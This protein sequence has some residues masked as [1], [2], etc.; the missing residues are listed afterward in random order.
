MAKNRLFTAIVVFAPAVLFLSQAVAVE[1]PGGESIL[2]VGASAISISPTQFPVRSAGGG[3]VD[4]STTALAD[5]L[6]SRCIVVDDGH[7]RIAI[8]VL[9]VTEFSREFADQ[10]KDATSARLGLRTDRILI[11]ATHTHSAPNTYGINVDADKKYMRLLVERIPLGIEQAVHNLRPAR[12]GWTVIQDWEHTHTR[13]W[14]RRPDKVD[15]DPL[16]ARTVRANMHPGFQNPDVIGPAGPSDP[17][18]SIVAFQGLDGHPIALLAH[19]SQHYYGV[20][21]LANGTPVLSADYFGAFASKIAGL[22]APDPASVWSHGFESSVYGI[23]LIKAYTSTDDTARAMAKDAPPLF[24]AIMAQGTSGDQQW[25]DYS[26]PAY[27]PGLDAYAHTI[28][29]EVFNAYRGIAYRNWAPVRM[30]ET[31]LT[32]GTRQPDAQEVQHAREVMASLHGRAPR[33]VT[34]SYAAAVMRAD[35]LPRTEELKLQAIAIGDLGFTAIPNEVYAITG[36]KIKAQSPF[37]TTINME[38]A[39]G[40][41]GYIPP[42]EQHVLG[43]YTTW[44]WPHFLEPQAE[45]K[46]VDTVLRLLEE[47]SG[48]PRHKPEEPLGVYDEVIL[49]SKPVAYWRLNEFNG[50]TAHD[51]TGLGHDAHY[52]DRVAFY[53]PGPD[54]NAFSGDHFINRAPH[55]AGSRIQAAL[56][57]PSDHYS[58]EF[59]FW[60]GLPADV[61]GITGW[62]LSSAADESIGIGGTAGS[63]GQLILA[64]DRQILKSGKSVLAPKT[65]YYLALV[66]DGPTVNVYLN[67]KGTPEISAPSAFSVTS[68]KHSLFFGGRADPPESFEGK[69]DDVA[70]YDRTL[71]PLEISDHFRASKMSNQQQ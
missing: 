6:H 43:G 44:R 63:A 42:P 54:S 4:S 52:E 32:V 9:D 59:W 16:G 19:Y 22:I 7:E 11:A 10:V 48:R 55:L 26:R 56:K 29:Q 25:M 21:W 27:G 17:D 35:A 37:V 15:L 14:I 1:P 8:A 40:G 49:G 51:A 70:V 53:L 57:L 64:S 46:I 2:R 38:L 66:R 33:T 58:V 69:L 5:N 34:E 45:P 20:P 30:T 23:D 67:G 28:A 60:N 24:V 3:F 68:P 31:K 71:T 65:W 50:P 39:N 41:N 36:L 18:I 62:L 47:V 13:R 12:V 61:R